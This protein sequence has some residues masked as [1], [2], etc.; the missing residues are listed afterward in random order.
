VP[1]GPVGAG[2]VDGGQGEHEVGQDRP[3]DGAGGLRGGVPGQVPT[4][5]AGAGAAAEEPVRGRDDRVE[6]R[7]GHRS[8]DQDQDAQG[9]RGRDRVLQ[10]LHA[11]VARGQ[12]GGHD[13]GADDG[14]DE[15]C[16]AEEL[17]EERSPRCAVD[18][19]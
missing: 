13:P 10:Q 3:G 14:G 7:A 18:H 15:Q 5:Q 12:P 2:E 17:G 1:G 11:D 6:V 4:G 19:R 16:G 9:E 8:E